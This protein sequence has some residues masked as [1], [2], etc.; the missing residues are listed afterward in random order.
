MR[1]CL[2]KYIFCILVLDFAL[3]G[4][5]CQRDTDFSRPT[6][7]MIAINADNFPDEVFREYIKRFDVNKDGEISETEACVYDSIILK[8]RNVSSLEGIQKFILDLE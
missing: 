3:S 4:I 2:A 1:K 5:A 7:I 8:N 6:Q